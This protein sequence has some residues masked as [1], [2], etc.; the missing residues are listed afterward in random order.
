MRCMWCFWRWLRLIIIGRQPLL[1]FVPH[2]N[3]NISGET[4]RQCIV[5]ICPHSSYRLGPYLRAAEN[6]NIHVLVVSQGEYS[7]VSEIASGVH[8]DFKKQEEAFDEIMLSS[9]QHEVVA[10]LGIDDMTVE[11]AARVS[12]SLGLGHNDL[13]ASRYTRRKDLA[14]EALKDTNVFIPEFKKTALH[15]LFSCQESPVGFPCVVKPLSLSG[16]RGVI[17]AHDL[18][19]LKTA[20]IRID[21]IL[22]NEGLT[23][24][25]RQYILV[26]QYMSG[27][28]Y[29]FEG[30][31]HKGKLQCLA[32]F[33]K[34]D[35][36]EGPYFEETYY[37][38]PSR[39]SEIWQ[40]KI[41]ETVSEACKLYGLKEGPIHAEVRIHENKIC[42][43]E[44]ASRTI[45]GQCAQI[46]Q[47]ATGLSLEEMVIKNAVGLEVLTERWK[48]AAG[49]LMIP[50]TE[51]GLLR[52]V[53]GILEASKIQFIEDIEISVSEGYELLPLPEGFSYLGFIFSKAPTPI[54]AEQALRNA[55][56][57]LKIITMPILHQS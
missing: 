29:A 6:L 21:A 23:G 54:E 10:V 14:R 20:A 42:F 3:D 28:E 53:E 13:K 50:T 30:M 49:V 52:R 2:P 17:C 9:S 22:Q 55:Y 15:D 24:E 19:E 51:R 44:M 39:L 27:Y 32:L 1:I 48:Y 25:E 57:K 8:V 43:M 18:S 34:P 47:Y 11:L 31:L 36:M 38:T 16:S 37:I 7:L 40:R 41:E 46:L 26:E 5:I 33:D 35:L 56:E 4:N 12:Q 45:G